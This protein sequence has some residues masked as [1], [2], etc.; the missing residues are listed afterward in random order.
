MDF[1]LTLNLDTSNFPN[2][3]FNMTGVAAPCWIEYS[4][5]TER[6]YTG[7][8][9]SSNLAELIWDEGQ[10]VSMVV[11]ATSAAMSDLLVVEFTASTINYAF[12]Y[13]NSGGPKKMYG[14][15]LYPQT[16][17]IQSTATPLSG[18]GFPFAD[19]TNGQVGLAVYTLSAAY[20]PTG[21]TGTGSPPTAS[22]ST[23]TTGGSSGTTGSTGTGTGSSGGSA[24]HISASPLAMLLIA[25]AV[26]ARLF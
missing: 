5:T 22:S 11:N 17:D 7:N 24:S 13:S 9:G 14:W 19:Q 18:T 4:D 8:A 25:A 15:S 16:Q 12:L 20:T 1:G 23:G 21:P 10:S 26:I 6:F 3:Y 2:G